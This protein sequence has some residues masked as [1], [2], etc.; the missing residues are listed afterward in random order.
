MRSRSGG[1]GSTVTASTT[2]AQAVTSSMVAGASPYSLRRSVSRL[3]PSRSASSL[4]PQSFSPA[5]RRV[6][7]A[8]RC[9]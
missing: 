3:T 1:A 2:S 8:A 5:T 4:I 6:S 9:W 7:Q